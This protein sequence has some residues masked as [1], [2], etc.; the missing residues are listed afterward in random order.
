MKRHIIISIIGHLLVFIALIV[1]AFLPRRP[2]PPVQMVT[3]RA[4][5]PQS[6]ERLLQQMEEPAQPKPTPKT[7]QAPVIKEKMLP[8]P[9]KAL[10][11]A[12]TVK[13]AEKE[14]PSKETPDKSASK[15]TSK[16]KKEIDAPDNIRTDQE[17]SNEYL[18]LLQQVIRNNWRAPKS[19]D[20]SIK[21][22]VFFQIAPNGKLQRIRV[23][24]PSGNMMFDR[25]AYEAIMKSN[26]LPALPDDFTSD[27]LGV[28]LVFSY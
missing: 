7:Q 28:H 20:L 5:S 25:S 19:N 13:R 1:P 4:V 14:P 11:K 6:V 24:T 18:A 22:T 9:A 23:E 12:Q 3:V 8:D 17:V 26:P 10:R 15:S 2:M 21:V 27:K 16:G